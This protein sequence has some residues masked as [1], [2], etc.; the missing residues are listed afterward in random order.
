MFQRD[1]WLCHVCRRPVVFHLALKYL[2]IDARV[3]LGDPSITYWH[4]NWR[5]DQAPLADE[6]GACVD[7]V[8]AFS[9]GGVHDVKNFATICSRCNTRKSAKT[10]AT[11]LEQL[12]PWR[13]RGK[14][15]EPERWDGLSSI[16]IVLARKHIGLLSTT[17]REWLAALE[18]SRSSRQGGTV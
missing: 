9:T 8:V 5:R 14:D 18:N 6:L 15:G 13:A 16:F 3:G 17:E 2:E 11:F 1:R 12:R 4:P 7:H 10:L